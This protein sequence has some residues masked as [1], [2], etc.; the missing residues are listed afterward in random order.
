MMQE[1]GGAECGNGRNAGKKHG[2]RNGGF[3]RNAE[4]NWRGAKYGQ[5]MCRNWM[6]EIGG[7]GG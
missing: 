2:M 4:W 1:Y 5:D 3:M 7:K 6:A